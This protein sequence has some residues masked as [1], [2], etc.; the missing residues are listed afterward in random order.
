MSQSNANLKNNVGLIKNGTSNVTAATRPIN[1][2]QGQSSIE[3][4]K[5]S[6][7]LVNITQIS[8]SQRSLLNQQNQS[9]NGSGDSQQQQQNLT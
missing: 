8:R 5:Q 7:G 2:A 1:M 3:L 4:P 6:N 9:L